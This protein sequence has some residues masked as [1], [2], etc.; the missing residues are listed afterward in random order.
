MFGSK[1][2]KNYHWLTFVALDLDVTDLNRNYGTKL[3]Y[4]NEIRLSPRK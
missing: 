4:D 3:G 2:T 1:D